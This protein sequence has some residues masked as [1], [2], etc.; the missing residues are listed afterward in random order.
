MSHLIE[1]KENKKKLL[2]D[3]LSKFHSSINKDLIDYENHLDSRLRKH[4]PLAPPLFQQ[5]TTPNLSNQSRNIKF[6]ILDANFN[7]LLSF[8]QVGGDHQKGKKR[9]EK[10]L[11]KEEAF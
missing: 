8:S 2:I 4:L 10:S 1:Q 9:S 11:K 3:P 6:G 7:D 5:Q